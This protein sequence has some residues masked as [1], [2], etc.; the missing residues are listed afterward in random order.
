MLDGRWVV[1]EPPDVVEVVDGRVLEINAGALS[2]FGG[3]ERLE[4]R[5]TAYW[6]G[7]D[8]VPVELTLRA[9]HR[10]RH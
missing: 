5:R 4:V 2:L 3:Q 10:S 7:H 1:T 9:F 8:I 6:Y